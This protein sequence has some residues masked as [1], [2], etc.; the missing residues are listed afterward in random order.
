MQSPYSFIVRPLKGKRYDNEKKI[1]DI[2]FIISVSK[3]DHKS[4]NRFAQVISVPISYKGEIKI[5][6][7]LLV[8]HNVFKFYYDMQGIEKSGK[9]FFRNDLFFIDPDQF[10][11]YYNGSEWRSHSKYCF[12]KPVPVKLSYLNKTG[13]E[14][15]LIGRMK[16]I[17]NQLEK[18]GVKV[19]DEISFTPDSEYEF[20]VDGEKLYRM[21]TENITMVLN[22]G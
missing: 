20:N 14:E 21:Y 18:L 11:L 9:S 6:D 17:N 10:F 13:K 2:D 8:H 1:G 3:E 22:N 19:G 5:G 15:P 16:F 12:V 4:S 7:I